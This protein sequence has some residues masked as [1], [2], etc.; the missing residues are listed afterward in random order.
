MS[1]IEDNCRALW[2]EVFG[3]SD[4]F[5]EHFM[6]HYYRRENFLY[7]EEEGEL[8][9]MLHLVPFRNNGNTIGIIY[10]LATTAVSRSKGYATLL[11]QRAK[12]RALSL[13][14]TAIALIPA[15]ASLFNYYNKRGFTG[16]Y[17]V[18]FILPDDFDFGIDD[19]ENQW[20]AI[21]PLKKGYTPILTSDTIALTWDIHNYSK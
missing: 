20:L 13:G 9:S 12:E 7:I 19:K 2:K 6:S 16:K 8:Q 17:R 10:A 11:L 18:E 5:I 3:D 1:K 14:Y 15:Q 21:M 4:S